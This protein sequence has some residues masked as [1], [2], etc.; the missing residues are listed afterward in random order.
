M[1][2]KQK[3]IN[4]FDKFRAEILEK[5]NCDTTTELLSDERKL[6]LVNAYLD[7]VSEG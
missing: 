5:L 6:R 1:D 7:I 4:Y 2:E 3:L